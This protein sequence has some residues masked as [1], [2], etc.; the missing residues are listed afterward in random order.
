MSFTTHIGYYTIMKK[1]ITVD[2]RKVDSN[3]IFY[4]LKGVQCDGHDFLHEVAARGAKEAVVDKGYA[5]ESFGLS[6]THVPDVLAHLQHVAK[7]RVESEKAHVIGITGSMGKTTVKEYVATLL[8]E[9]YT[10]GK[11]FGSYNGQI[12]LPLS[13]L[14]APQG[15]E[16]LV[17]EMGMSLPGEMARLAEIAQPH[18]A[19][20][21]R[22]S[23]SHIGN[24][25]GLEAIATEKGAI[26]TSKRLERPLVSPQAAP[27]F[28]DREVFPLV[29]GPF[30]EDHLAECFSAAAALARSVGLT[31]EEIARGAKKLQP[32]R[33]RF[34]R[35]EREG[36]VFI[37]DSYNA[38]VESMEAALRNLPRGKRRIAVLGEMG[39][40]GSYAEEAHARVGAYARGRVDKL[41]VFG[42]KNGFGWGEVFSDFAN[43]KEAV[44]NEVR[45]GDVVLLKGANAKRLWRLLEG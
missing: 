12:G 45:A 27:F 33:H 18:T 28:P 36:I 44:W 21:T 16:V 38:N 29:E 30:A 35:V 37:D 39:E 26:F 22:I 1:I 34:E 7:E 25:S 2:S 9:R 43:L 40:L 32:Y 3:S 41:F 10:V 11:S 13:I 14:N 8:S 5:G 31:D 15:A 24:F 17:F 4:A 6:L 20:I 19:L 23:S 42:Q